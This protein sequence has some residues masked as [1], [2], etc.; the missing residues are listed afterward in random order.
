[1]GTMA[2]LLPS[3]N[4]PVSVV[5]H[6]P[7]AE[8]AAQEVLESV[9]ASRAKDL[10][11]LKTQ[12]NETMSAKTPPRNRLIR[13]RH[14]AGQQSAIFSSKSACSSGCSHCC[15]IDVSVPRSEAMLIGKMTGKRVSEPSVTFPIDQPPAKSFVGSPCPFLT[16]GSCSIYAHRPL[17]CRTLVNLDRSP[18]LCE[19]VP[20]ATIPV[21]YLNTTTLRAAFTIVTQSEDFAD[22]REWFGP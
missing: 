21:P 10:Q 14:I 7:A 6:L 3:P 9:S 12:L 20:N 17:L 18:K 8:A 15:H 22:I 2:K 5:Q 4:M 19:L 16:E 11:A 1:M 13:I